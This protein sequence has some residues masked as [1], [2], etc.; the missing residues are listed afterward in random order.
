M[1]FVYIATNHSGT[2]YI[3]VTNNLER[4][5]FEHKNRLVSGFTS[6]YKINRL[7]YYETTDN[8]RS[9]I[10]REKQLKGWSR[11]KKVNLIESDNR[12]WKDLSADWF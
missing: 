7:V 8:I 12:G 10:E 9:A 6:R 4:R 5:M 1:Y 2:L 11:A 3:G